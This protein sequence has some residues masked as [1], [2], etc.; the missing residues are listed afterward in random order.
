MVPII[1][2]E[3]EEVKKILCEHSK[4][5]DLTRDKIGEPDVLFASS[6]RQ[7]QLLGQLD[8]VSDYFHLETMISG[9]ETVV[10]KLYGLYFRALL[11]DASEV[12][13]GNVLKLVTN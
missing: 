12:W 7:G 13:P 8:R 5:F 9:F 11:P 4:D 3:K 10:N 2:S 1:G 6:V